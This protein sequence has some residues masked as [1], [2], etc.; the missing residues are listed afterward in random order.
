MLEVPARFI[1]IEGGEGVGKSLF[2]QKFSEGLAGLGVK[3]KTT[4]EPGGT[5]IADRLRS[6]FHAPP[7][8]EQL[9][10]ESE[11]CII[12]AAR[13]QH[14]HHVIKPELKKNSWVI[15]DRF[16][17][18]SRVY[19]GA[20]GGVQL[21]LLEQINS[22]VCYGLQPDLTFVLDCDV[23]TSLAR[24]QERVDDGAEA[25]RYDKA[26][27]EFHQKVRDG[28]LELSVSFPDRMVVLDASRATEQ[29]VVEAL[30]VVR[31]RFL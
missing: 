20:I 13:A 16:S 30:D 23:R 21:D 9:T 4:R 6:I 22:L 31:D 19:Q 25:S 17:D 29:S 26:Q 14:I 7:E 2:T 12:C 8:N 15:C 3:H 24:I 28:F 11:L 18:S 1:T 10:I 27:V 5:P